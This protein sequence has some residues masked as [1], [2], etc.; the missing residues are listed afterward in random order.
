M[1]R[2]S[3]LAQVLEPLYASV[4]E[5]ARMQDFLDRM[6]T[7]TGSCLGGVIVEDLGHGQGSI[8]MI[9]GASDA[10][11]RLYEQKFAGDNV[12]IN[13]SMHALVTGR[14]FD[15]DDWVPR[16]DLLRSRY[17]NEFL[18]RFDDMRQSLALCALRDDNAVVMMTL[19]R[20]GRFDRFTERQT[21]LAQ[22]VLPHWVNAYA[23]QRRL[24]RL[25]RRTSSL[26]QTLHEHGDAMFMLAGNGTVQGM[27][28]AAEQC[29]QPAGHLRLEQGRLVI[30]HDR[31]HRFA[32]TLHEA[33]VG[34]SCDGDL[35]RHQ[36]VAPVRDAC[37][38]VVAIVNAHPLPQALDM[39]TGSDPASNGSAAAMLFVQPLRSARKLG[40]DAL[41]R[42]LFD[43]TRAEAALAAA[44]HDEGDLARAAEACRIAH[45][46]AQSRI[47]LVYDK[48]GEHGQAALVRL[49]SAVAR[50]L[51]D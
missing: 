8:S 44:L 6:S 3:D 18:R 42:Q 38:R 20:S 35:Q 30:D 31:D 26:E 48:T 36:G 23:V 16:S 46:T 12:W 51:P 29:L 2:E 11:R 14:L 37:G 10:D 5:P 32:R 27:N 17:Y 47:K 33:T 4:L 22:Q 43:L 41:L 15:S 1:S 19:G 50:T 25:E 7:L 28:A 13:A 40:L 45:S 34:R 39:P 21:S 49:L 24:S 9:N